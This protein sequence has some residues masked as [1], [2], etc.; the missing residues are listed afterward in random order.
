MYVK[1]K[2]ITN[3]TV[4]KKDYAVSSAMD[5][6][7]SNNYHRLPVVDDDNNVIGLVTKTVIRK[8]SPNDA[9]SLSV[10]ELNYLL[11]KLK[12]GDIMIKEPITTSKDALLE[13]AA[14]IMLENSVGCLPVVEGKKL[15]GI[16]TTKDIFS[17]FIDILGY[18]L[19]GTRYVINI[20]EDK[21]GVLNDISACFK[22]QDISISNLAVYNTIRGIE[23]VVIATGKNSGDCKEALEKAKYNVTSVTK[24]KKKK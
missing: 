15:V 1:D 19:N 12:V 9:S 13:E 21:V 17:A 24:L 6:M 5:I 2:M 20:K 22:K 4:V 3:V 8:N 10:F 16:I 11:N 23:V 14:D 7:T 18:H